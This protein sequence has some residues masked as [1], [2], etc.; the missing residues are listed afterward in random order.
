M[1][2]IILLVFVGILFVSCKKEREISQQEKEK[3]VAELNQIRI[4]DQKYAGIP[5]FYLK[6]KYG[7]Q[8]AWE[9][10]EQQR[11]SVSIANQNKI[12][13][14]YENY[15]YI[16]EKKVGEETATSFWVPIQHADNNIPFQQEMLKAMKKEIENGSKDNYHYAMLEDRVNVN[17]KKPQRFGSQVTY[18]DKG[19]AI[20]KIGLVD[21]T[22]VDSLRK[23][24]NLPDFK[25]YYNGMTE[26]H[27]EMNKKMFLEKGITEP[28]LYK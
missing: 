9:I 17:L 21:S 15:G 10:F 11:D 27:F 20:P 8:K 19:Q 13:Q 18:N 22:I 4:I 24:Y 6:E 1:K 16:G 25:E 28:Q 23:A 14:L 12:K 26:M 2:R 7:N 5:P 3:I